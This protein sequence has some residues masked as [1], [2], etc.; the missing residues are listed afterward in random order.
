MFITSEKNYSAAEG[1]WKGKPSRGLMW[2]LDLQP[3]VIERC[4]SAMGYASIVEFLHKEMGCL[5]WSDWLAPYDCSNDFVEKVIKQNGEIQDITYN[6][7]A[8]SLHEI[9]RKGQTVEHKVKSLDDLKLLMKMWEN[10]KIVPAIDRFNKALDTGRGKWPVIPSLLECS[11]VQNFLQNETG[12][13]NFWYMLADDTLLVEE[14]MKIWQELMKKK[15][16]I[17]RKL[18]CI[19]FFQ[20]ENTSTTMISPFFYKKYSLKHIQDLT[21]IAKE[22]GKRTLIHMCGLLH[23]LMPLLNESG[24]NGIHALTTPTTGDTCFRYAFDIMPED[25][26][27][28]GRFGS[29]FWYRKNRQEILDALSFILP[30]EIY[31]D[32]AFTLLITGDGLMDITPEN[33]LLLRDCINEYE[34]IA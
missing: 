2:T 25:F 33:L 18:P 27:T 3:E 34:K 32:H 5:I 12:V 26:F 4:T 31:M 8:G 19:G 16:E 7:P 29:H 21:L 30:H 15:Y 17:I 24:M 28:L 6:S 9:R 22:E 14:A 20:T 10:I 11:P 1:F 23:D 13:E